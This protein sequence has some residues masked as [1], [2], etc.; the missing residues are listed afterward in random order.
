MVSRCLLSN[1]LSPAKKTQTTVQQQQEIQAANS[2]RFYRAENC[3]VNLESNLLAVLLQQLAQIHNKTVFSC[4]C[5]SRERS[6][7]IST[8]IPPL[9]S[10]QHS[11][12][13]RGPALRLSYIRTPSGGGGSIRAIYRTR[14]CAGFVPWRSAAA[15]RSLQP[16]EGTSRTLA[17]RHSAHDH[18]SSS[19]HESYWTTHLQR[20]IIPRSPHL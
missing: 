1:C 2:R 4:P 7:S 9:A 20:P 15:R 12:P 14:V 6:R 8:T 11:S 17:E 19:V 5:S 16:F 3:N 13:I 18:G 10:P